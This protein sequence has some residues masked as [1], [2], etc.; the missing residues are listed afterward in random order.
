MMIGKDRGNREIIIPILN[1][2]YKVIVCW[3]DEKWLNKVGLKWGYNNI[4]PTTGIERGLT[5]TTDDLDRQPIIVLP[6]YPKAP[7]EIGTLAH[8]ATHAID[9]IFT[10]IR[11]ESK[12]TYREVYAHSVGAVVRETLKNGRK[13]K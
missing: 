10:I 11:E 1:T 8:E 7:M 12:E 2:E 9:Y 6:R 5:Y 4:K 3:G 13:R